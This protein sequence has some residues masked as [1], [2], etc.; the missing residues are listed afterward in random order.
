MKHNMDVLINYNI[1]KLPCPGGMIGHYSVFSRDSRT[2]VV[3]YQSY[4]QRNKR[5]AKVLDASCEFHVNDFNFG[6][7]VLSL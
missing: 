6:L 2:T 3:R 5:A 1:N 4:S 7:L